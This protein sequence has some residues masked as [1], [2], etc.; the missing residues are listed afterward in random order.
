M[1]NEKLE[2]FIKEFIP[3]SDK[4]ARYRNNHIEKI[5]D[6]IN[7]IFKN[8]FGANEKFDNEFIIDAFY[9]L[10]FK[11]K[12]INNP[13]EKTFKNNR[14]VKHVWID[15]SAYHILLLRVIL[16]NQYEKVAGKRK[17]DIE[18]MLEKLNKFK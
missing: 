14:E 11:I 3:K 18:L 6:T 1:S 8:Y 16:K 5:A 2:K 4:L 7:R 9:N 15:V 12:E 13:L 17:I 10:G